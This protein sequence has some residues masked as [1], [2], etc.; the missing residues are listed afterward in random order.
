MYEYDVDGYKYNTV[1]N[2]LKA[3]K[4]TDERE[5]GML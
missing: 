3:H 2:K 4:T 5:K 1:L